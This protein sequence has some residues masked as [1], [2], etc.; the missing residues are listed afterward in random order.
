MSK[1]ILY[2]NGYN[3][4]L[5]SFLKDI[6]PLNLELT[7]EEG[8]Y[9]N[10]KS[11][12]FDFSNESFYDYISFIFP[13]IF[14]EDEKDDFL[15][16]CINSNLED[17]LSSG[18]Y[19]KIQNI[20]INFRSS[21]YSKIKVKVGSSYMDWI[22][23]FIPEFNS[24]D[25]NR[26]FVKYVNRHFAEWINLSY[27]TLDKRGHLLKSR[28]YRNKLK[29]E[30]SFIKSFNSFDFYWTTN[31]FKDPLLLDSKEHFLVNGDILDTNEVLFDGL[32]HTNET[33][34]ALLEMSNNDIRMDILK[35]NYAYIS[36]FPRSIGHFNSDVELHIF[37]LSP[38]H[39]D[40]LMVAIKANKNIK[41]IIYY[42]LDDNN[43]N[44]EL[45]NWNEK[46][47]NK[48]INYFEKFYFVPSNLI[49]TSEIFEDYL[50]EK[51]DSNK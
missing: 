12:D 42:Y 34:S 51:N 22:E 23:S 19:E 13:E 48:L 7:K 14:P 5:N 32:I 18:A 16:K 28:Y 46:V 50:I 27:D 6:E 25:R 31:F 29:S 2:G 20:S 21:G 9:T 37:G 30:E 1:V 38:I 33:K 35:N 36:Q 41:K 40:D 39:D 17:V 11:F 15:E 44:V 49:S 45:K 4:M 3:S 8:L 24:E 47:K 26:T 43:G 10:K